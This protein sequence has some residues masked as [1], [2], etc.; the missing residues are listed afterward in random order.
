MAQE[1]IRTV[2][3]QWFRSAIG[4]PARQG[5]VV[6]GLGLNRLNQ[7]VERVDTPQIRGMVNKIPHL[8]KI[9]LPAKPR[10]I[11][12]V[13]E[14]SIPSRGLAKAR[15]AAVPQLRPEQVK[16]APQPEEPTKKLPPRRRA[17]PEPEKDAN[18]AKKAPVYG[19]TSS[20]QKST[21][22]SKAVDKKKKKK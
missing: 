18:G 15:P 4:R 1:K 14:Y 11:D 9:V 7:V 17:P 12:S 5:K 6:Q 21:K 20:T 8:V 10:L 2:H 16:A 22:D 3:I 19:K 13:P